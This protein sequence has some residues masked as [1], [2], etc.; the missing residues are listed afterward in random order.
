M[1]DT[2]IVTIPATPDR[3]LT[4][5]AIR[6]ERHWGPR[7]RATKQ[8]REAAY[9]A[10][11]NANLEMWE[12]EALVIDAVIAW[13]KVRTPRYP[14][15]RYRQ[16]MDPDNAH[17]SLKP[18]VDGIADA[19]GIND[20]HITLATVQQERDEAGAGFVRMAIREEAA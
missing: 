3:C 2:I 17:A 10:G 18:F 8:A 15:G 20:K 6:S 5:N 4:P 1:P 11:C 13:E 16:Y 19:L 9:Y 12:P 7:S 14:N